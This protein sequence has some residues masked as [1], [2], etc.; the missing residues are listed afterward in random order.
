[1]YSSKFSF[2]FSF[3]LSGLIIVKAAHSSY[4]TY[5]LKN[6]LDKK[7]SENIYLETTNFEYNYFDLFL[8]FGKSFLFTLNP[9]EKFERRYLRKNPIYVSNGLLLDGKDKT[10][11]GLDLKTHEILINKKLMEIKICNGK[12]IVFNKHLNIVSKYDLDELEKLF[13]LTDKYIDKK[14]YFEGIMKLRGAIISSFFFK[15]TLKD[16]YKFMRVN[17]YNYIKKFDMDY[18][19]SLEYLNRGYPPMWSGETDI[20][21]EI[22]KDVLNYNKKYIFDNFENFKN[23]EICYLYPEETNKN[24]EK[25]IKYIYHRSPLYHYLFAIKTYICENNDYNKDLPVRQ[26]DFHVTLMENDK[27]EFFD[28]EK[29]HKKRLKYH[30]TKINLLDRKKWFVGEK[31]IQYNLGK[32][33]ETN[34]EDHITICYYEDGLPDKVK[35]RFE[36]LFK[37]NLLEKNL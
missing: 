27:K 20:Y 19:S 29:V 22:V 14:D 17:D 3:G 18:L 36:K 32:N 23:V 26:F 7:K 21:D 16:I 2:G 10:F 13:E 6:A 25:Q 34:K 30:N 31:Q 1:M 24:F 8:D 37:L 28:E 11:S 12:M 35:E 15:S 33:Y 9:F 4:F 5:C